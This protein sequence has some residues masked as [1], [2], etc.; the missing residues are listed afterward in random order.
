MKLAGRIV[1]AAPALFVVAF[2]VA[3]VLAGSTAVGIVG[4]AFDP[5]TIT[6][7][8][9]DTVTW[10]VNQSIGE[11]HSVTSGTPQDAGKQFDSGINLK[12]NGQS[13][14]FT[15][16]D[17]GEYVYYCQVHPVEMTG[18]VVVL[19]AGASAPP[20]IAPTPAEEKTGVP[21]DRRLLAGSILVIALVPMFGMAY[22]WRRMNPA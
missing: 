15:F 4:K 13:F 8:A 9:G 11:P 17:P 3:P 18:K 22:V 7:S 14:Q 2:V 6:I 16:K 21:A 19:A 12:D 1:L 5:T 10:T 20:S